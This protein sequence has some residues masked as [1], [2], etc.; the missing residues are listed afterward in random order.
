[1]LPQIL[2]D[3]SD[4]VQTEKLN[5]H[6]SVPF[7]FHL[8]LL[9]FSLSLG[10]GYSPFANAAEPI[11]KDAMWG[12]CT[13]QDSDIYLPDYAPDLALDESAVEANDMAVSQDGT[14]TLSGRVRARHNANTLYAEQVVYDESLSNMDATGEVNFWTE[15]LFWQGE[16][17]NIDRA[18]NVSN[19]D[20]GYYRLLDRRGHG[21]AEKVVDQANENVTYLTDVDYTTCPGGPGEKTPWR[22]KAKDLKLDHNANWGRA[23]HA[24]LKVK[25]IPVFYFP[26]LSFPLTDER[27]SGFLAP[28]LGSTNDSGLDFRIP[29][30]WNISPNMDA[31]F[32]PRVLSDRGVMLGS[33]FRYLREGGLGTVEFEML[34]SDNLEGTNRYLFSTKLTQRFANVRGRLYINYNQASDKQYFEDLS[35]SLDVTSQRILDRRADISYQGEWWRVLG[36]VQ[37]YQSVDETLLPRQVPYAIL[38]QFLFQTLFRE[39][40]RTLNY[41]LRAETVYFDHSERVN[42]NRTDILGSINYPMRT[43]GAFLTPSLKLRH[44]QYF[45][46]GDATTTNNNPSRTLPIASLDSGLFFERNLDLGGETYLHTLEPRIFYLYV[47]YSDQ[48]DIPVFDT[49]QF[50]TSFA[51]LFQDNRFNA[52]DRVGDANQVTLALTTRLI[53]RHTGRERIA[54]SVGQIR[55]FED[56]KVTLPGRLVESNNASSYVAQISSQITDHLRAM[57]DIQWNPEDKATEKSSIN[58]RY[59]PKE[60]AVFNVA[61]RMRKSISDIEQTDVSFRWPLTKRWSTVG[62]WNYSLQNDRTIEGLFGFEYNSCCWATRV[63]ARHFLRNTEGEYDDAIF[64]QF[65]LKGLAGFGRGAGEFLERNIPGYQDE[66]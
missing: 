33:E 13:D 53:E 27:M 15:G 51:Q 34:P 52:A 5:N 48:S 25:D 59:Q 17:A 16:H 60:N 11:S 37:S 55:Y 35:S 62:R 14:T 43:A 20:Q 54:A 61:Y 50:D 64:F 6:N 18:E 10:A 21:N 32:T 29:Y 9:A 24:I 7:R 28:T 36:R 3:G 26:Y 8:T 30:Y 22:F 40:N 39:R 1:M 65:E 57:Y 58:I 12:L 47:P 45:I 19:F 38:P 41:S 56:R 31:T 23:I 46:D 44:T 49:G 63:V 42:G 2:I 4:P 66:F